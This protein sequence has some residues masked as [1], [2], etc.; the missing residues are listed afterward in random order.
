MNGKALLKR[1]GVSFITV[2]AAVLLTFFILRMMPGDA[3]ETQA[4]EMARTQGIPIEIAYERIADMYNYDPNEPVIQQLGRYIGN[5]LQGNLGTSMIYRNITVNQ[6]VAKALPWTIFVLSISLSISFFIGINLGTIMA[7]KR[8]SILEP[9]ISG[10]AILSSALPNFIVAVLLLIIFA[11]QLRWFPIAGAYGGDVTPGFNLP[12]ILSAL[13]HAFL[14][15]LTYVVTT[16][17]SWALQMKGSAVNILGEDY[18]NAAYM[19]GVPDKKIMNNYVRK[20]AMLP[21]ITSFAISFG[22][23]LGGSAL[24]EN[25]FGYPGMGYYIGQATGQ[26]DFTLMQGLLLVTSLAVIIANLI[27]DLVY[28]KLDPRVSLDK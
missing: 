24:I 22:V 19:R 7:W 17:G 8:N 15:I 11:F 10:Y 5:L 25:T 1:V 4:R 3:I 26:R 28:S 13:K 20:N 16:L 14:P 12:F 23:M 27:A 21:L 18:V 2:L 6:I 9:I